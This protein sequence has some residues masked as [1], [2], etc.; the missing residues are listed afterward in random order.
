MSEKTALSLMLIITCSISAFGSIFIITA[1]LYFK[2]IR[3]FAFKL[4]FFMSISDLVRSI[5]LMLPPE[6]LS[7]KFQ[8]FLL[9]FST[10]SSILWSFNI[11]YSLYT[12]VINQENNP[13]RH[14]TKFLLLAYLFPFLLAFIPLF[15]D[16]YNNAVGWCWIQK[17]FITDLVERIFCLYIIIWTV[18]AFNLSV[19]WKIIMKIR[20]EFKNVIEDQADNNAVIKRLSLYPLTLILC[21]LPITVKRTM[22]IGGQEILPFWFLCLSAFGISIFGFANALVYGFSRPVREAIK[23]LFVKD[24]R[25][26]S[27]FSL[28]T[29]K[30]AGSFATN[31]L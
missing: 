14:Q 16:S 18:I 5:S 21:Y 8:G 7:C 15:T 19:Y 29:Q 3:S 22:E 12:T 31:N 17:D 23:E 26:Q 27:A 2:S 6:G 24:F 20:K 30:F 10:A 9:Q 28:Y 1:F 11:A 4:V 13:S 25:S